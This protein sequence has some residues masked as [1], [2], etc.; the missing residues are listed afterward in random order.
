MTGLPNQNAQRQ[1]WAAGRYPGSPV[2]TSGTI[3]KSSELSDELGAVLTGLNIV[4][5]RHLQKCHVLRDVL[6][7]V[8]LNGAVI[9]ER[10]ASDRVCILGTGEVTR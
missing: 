9:S 5:I 6:G 2:A 1:S 4:V 10:R 7:L 3:C 8:R